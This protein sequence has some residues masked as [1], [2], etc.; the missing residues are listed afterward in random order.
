MKTVFFADQYEFRK[1]LEKNHKKE[2]ELIAGY[3]KRETGKPSMTW[4]ESVDQALCFGWIDGIR[5]KI[6]EESYCIRFTPRRPGSNWSK[7]NISK[8]EEMKKAGLMTQ[9]GLELYN[10]RKETSGER[11]SYENLPS[12]LPPELEKTFRKNKKA[13]DFFEKQ[14][15]SYRKVR[16]YWI[17]SSKQE[18][19]RLNRFNK[20]IEASEAGNRLF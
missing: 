11:Y 7:L 20:L 5:R 13:W 10:N 6:D 3:Y 16:I 19:T 9:A 12:E 15:P 8:V 2:Q 17:M 18:Q 14:A 1:W 4:S